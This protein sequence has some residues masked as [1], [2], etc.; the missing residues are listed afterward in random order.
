MTFLNAILS[1]G[2]LAFTIPLAIH[3][4]F[5]N[6]FRTVDWG[7]MHLLDSVVRI[8]HRRIELLQILLLL[9]RCLIP[10]LLA[11]CLARPVLTGF[12]ALPGDSPESLILA[13]DESRS[14]SA[15]DATGLSSI[16]RARQGLQSILADLSRRDE[17]I[18]VRSS[19]LDSAPVTTGRADASNKL[20]SMVAVA[21]PVDLSRLISNAIE[22]TDDASH[23]QR[24]ILI[25]S[26]FQS[27]DLGDQTIKSLRHVGDRLS[28]DD[29]G[30]GI[31][32]LDVRGESE[33]L[34]NVFVD[35]VTVDS[36]A[37]VSG[38][39]ARL[40]AQIR[41]D[42]DSPKNGLR[43]QWLV[44]GDAVDSAEIAL[45]SRAST[46]VRIDHA[47]NKQGIHELAVAVENDDAIHADNR[48]AIGVDV[49][50]EVSVVIV[51]GAPSNQ[52][53]RAET[54]FL[55]VALS[56]FA[57][58]EV[59]RADAVRTTV[60]PA[61]QIEQTIGEATHNIV[62]LAN[63]DRVEDTA[64]L[65]IA[66]FVSNGGS[67][68]IFDGD[69]LQPD[70]YNVRWKGTNESW[71]LPATIGSVIGEPKSAN[72]QPI[73]I[74]T[75]NQLYTPWNELGGPDGSLFETVDLFR[76]RLLSIDSED[77]TDQAGPTTTMLAA[78]NGDPL[79]VAAHRGRG[80]VVQFAFPCDEA[81]SGFPLRAV[82]VPMMQQLMLDLA[83]SQKLT[84]FELGRS[85]SLPTTDLHDE[86]KSKTQ[87]TYRVEYPDGSIKPVVP[88]PATTPAALLVNPK[89]AGVYRFH[90]EPTNKSDESEPHSTIR[91]VEVPS[92]E[93]QL[94][95][96]D[97]TRLQAAASS[98]QATVYTDVSELQSEDHTRRYGRE[99]WRWL[100]AL[101]LVAMIGEVILQQSLATGTF[102][103][104]SSSQS[105]PRGPEPPITPQGRG[106]LS[107][108]VTG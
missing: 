19:Q 69:L 101:L 16:E 84:T 2:A 56:P 68:V 64:R 86:L 25:V 81:W 26:D 78:A 55:T 52:P 22:A 61:T 49:I 42:N 104:E 58:G 91:I 67:L 3:L 100:L 30:S 66:D 79:I 93:S 77:V 75:Q 34:E 45:D 15:R 57:F 70:A 76:H 20:R 82:F 31:R 92:M 72:K 5:R 85:I 10:V 74:D 73:A 89:Q 4:L 97:P 33:S 7:A 59:E 102:R 54:D 24:R 11:F 36:P 105:P 62:V 39:E 37:V 103:L 98:V 83:G 51:D 23:A 41:N 27:I 80:R 18:L 6:R 99:V 17:V 40:S 87:V 50:D 13:I 48:R 14:M 106:D 94:R 88:D 38:R 8:N 107:G 35:S 96:A 53:L 12:R 108:E 47:F 95:D 65:A 21:G 29:R 28:K 43:I 1:L 9:L 46:T 32:F 60:I 71:R 44:D 90:A 63:V